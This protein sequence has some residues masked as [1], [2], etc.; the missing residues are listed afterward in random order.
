MKQSILP[1]LLGSNGPGI[2]GCENDAIIMYNLFYKYYL[3]NSLSDKWLKPHILLNNQVKLNLVEQIIE[4]TSFSKLIFYYSGHGYSKGQLSFASAEQIYQ[5]ISS[6]LRQDIDITFILDC[7][8]SG[9]FPIY[10]NKYS[11]IKKCNLIASCK[12][13]QK[14][15]ESLAFDDQ[16]LFKYKKPFYKRT[17]NF[18]T[19]IFT[20]NFVNILFKENTFTF[21]FRHNPIWL[22]IEY[23]AK[24]SLTIK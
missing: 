17:R 9:S 1:I 6:K 21:N 16:D 3:S 12:S 5:S 10:C 15:T 14:S 18:I 19:G 24:Q 22:D 20:Y 7:C 13:Y 23:I 8:K 2:N 4:S 11:F